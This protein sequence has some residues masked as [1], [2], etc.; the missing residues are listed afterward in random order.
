MKLYHPRVNTKHRFNTY[1]MKIYAQL[2]FEHKNDVTVLSNFCIELR[3]A[4]SVK[5]DNDCDSILCS[6]CNRTQIFIE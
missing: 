5:F 2:H 1:S 6:K 4:G 3:V